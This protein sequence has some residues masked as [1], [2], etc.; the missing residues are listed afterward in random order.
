[1]ERLLSLPGVVYLVSESLASVFTGSFSLQA[2]INTALKK[3]EVFKTLEH[4]AQLEV[5][6]RKLT[7]GTGNDSL[8]WWM[9]PDSSEIND[10][11][12]DRRKMRNLYFSKLDSIRRRSNK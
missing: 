10:K 7:A 3:A 6:K 8:G 11:E 12:T 4:D 5:W 2:E 1:M 9:A